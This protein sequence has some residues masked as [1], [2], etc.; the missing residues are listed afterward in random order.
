MWLWKFFQMNFG[1]EVIDIV[2]FGFGYDDEIL[3]VMK[4]VMICIDFDLDN[5][6]MSEYI[7][8]LFLQILYVCVLGG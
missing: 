7:F 1:V 3:L 2:L 6:F 8:R 4:V 5:C